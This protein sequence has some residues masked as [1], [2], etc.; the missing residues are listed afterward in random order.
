[1]DGKD[2]M[3]RTVIDSKTFCYYDAYT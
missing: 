1:M 2:G 3:E